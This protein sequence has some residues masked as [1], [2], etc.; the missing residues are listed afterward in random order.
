MTSAVDERPDGG[1]NG[2]LQV[3]GKSYIVVS[4]CQGVF[5]DMVLERQ[6]VLHEDS[7]SVGA[8]ASLRANEGMVTHAEGGREPGEE[9]EKRSLA[10]RRDGKHFGG[11]WKSVFVGTKW[12]SSGR[13]MTTTDVPSSQSSVSGNSPS[14]V[15]TIPLDT[16]PGIKS[17]CP[18]KSATNGVAGI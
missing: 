17:A 12:M 15:C 2:I 8:E 14:S 18:T 10:R 11:L 5:T 7:A 16:V 6:G 4:R 9:S 1:G 13:I 3:T